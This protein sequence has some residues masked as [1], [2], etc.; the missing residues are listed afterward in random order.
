MEKGIEQIVLNSGTLIRKEYTIDDYRTVPGLKGV[1]RDIYEF[2]PG[3]TDNIEWLVSVTPNEGKTIEDVLYEYTEQQGQD[4]FIMCRA[5]N[6]TPGPD[7]DV[8]YNFLPHIEEERGHILNAD[9]YNIVF[10][11]KMVHSYSCGEYCIYSNDKTEEF[12]RNNMGPDK[13]INRVMSS[14]KA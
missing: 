3:F 11:R 14:G 12:I 1:V 10:N 8:I 13:I 6:L 5:G 4:K 9:F 2:V 7:S